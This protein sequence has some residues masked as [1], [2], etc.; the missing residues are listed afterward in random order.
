MHLKEKSSTYGFGP[1]MLLQWVVQ[2]S[3]TE[4]FLN[5]LL[6]YLTSGAIF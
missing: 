3:I 6:K 4:E 5:S 1:T 2:M